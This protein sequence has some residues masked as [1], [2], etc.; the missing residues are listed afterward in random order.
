M[1]ELTKEQKEKLKN[2]ERDI[3]V[4]FK[5]DHFEA[6]RIAVDIHPRKPQQEAEAQ[7]DRVAQ[8]EVEVR[9]LDGRVR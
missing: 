3:K 7:R 1:A 9:H 8:G 6:V 5:E 2:L 4:S